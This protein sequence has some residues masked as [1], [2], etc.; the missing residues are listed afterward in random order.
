MHTYYW[1]IANEDEYDKPV[2][3]GVMKIFFMMMK[4]EQ[5]YS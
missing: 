4:K 2:V 3:I 1:E 5:E